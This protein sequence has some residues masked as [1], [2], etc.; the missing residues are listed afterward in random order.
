MPLNP[1][2]PAQAGTQCA[3]LGSRLRGNDG[4]A[5]RCT[6]GVPTTLLNRIADNRVQ[7]A[8]VDELHRKIGNAVF[9]S[10]TVDIDDVG[11]V[12]HRDRASLEFEPGD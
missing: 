2:I 8:S 12:Q 11:M 10:G 3:R 4:T 6:N 1:V 9:N 7:T 5:V